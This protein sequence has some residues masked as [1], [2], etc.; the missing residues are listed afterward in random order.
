M[1]FALK[2]MPDRKQIVRM[3]MQTGHEH[4]LSFFCCRTV[5]RFLYIRHARRR[6]VY[7]TC[8]IN[9]RSE[10]KK[11]EKRCGVRMIKFIFV[12]SF[13][14]LNKEQIYVENTGDLCRAG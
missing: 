1:L 9:R 10:M 4:Y 11:T 14:S 3:G 6:M 12:H 5:Q 2:T 7:C 13:Y 8:R